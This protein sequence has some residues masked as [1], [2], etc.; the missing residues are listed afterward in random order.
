M[1]DV[2]VIGG[3]I[4]G[5]ATGRALL[6]R[7]PKTRLLLLEKEPQL[8]THQTGRNSGVVHSGIYYRPGSLKARLCVEG[9]GRLLQFC[10]ERGIATRRVGKVIVAVEERE[11][12]ALATLEERGRANG[13]AGL[14]RIGPDRLRELEPNARGIAA[15]HLPHVAVVDFVQIAGAMARDIEQA[16]GVIQTS[17]CV[18]RVA[19]ADGCWRLDTT[20][21][22]CAGAFLINCGGLHSD[23]LGRLAG[24]GVSVRII[25]FR[26]EYF[27]LRPE[28]SSLVSGL[29][30]P[31]PDPALPFLGVHFTKMLD[32]EVHVGP[33]AVLATAREGYRRGDVSLR[34]CAELLLY[35]GFW[36]MSARF[37][38][39]GLSEW[40]RSVNPRAFLRAAQRLVPSLR[41]ADLCESPSGVRAQAVDH[42]GTL[43]DDFAV[44]SSPHALH[45]YN[46]PSPAATASLAIADQLVSELP[47]GEHHVAFGG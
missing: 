34:D 10:K 17:T 14:T 41:A 20:R 35:P 38:R 2:I 26:G 42:Q 13:V 16:G 7:S 46:A 40:M 45:V 39:L 31:V 3:G 47:V 23:R 4:I 9:G 8:A 37:W 5:L 12:S 29:I 11:L 22:D 30:Y 18:R 43:L 25:P 32:G 19:R 44:H 27:T 24:D 33:N 15:L 28:R 6:K 1:F 21:Q 36:K